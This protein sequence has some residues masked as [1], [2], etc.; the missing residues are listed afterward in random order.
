MGLL[1]PDDWQAR[2]I[3]VKESASASAAEVGP[4]RIV[5]ASYQALGGTPARDVT[6]LVSR[7]VS[8]N[9]LVLAVDN[10]ALGGD[11]AVGTKKQLV[12]E[13][14]LAGKRQRQQIQENDTLNINAAIA[15]V[16]PGVWA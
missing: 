4:L 15:G 13:Y 2:W 12:V 16:S 6:E 14:E 10:D 5:S 9:S 8:G 3:G 7:K 11:C 1:Q